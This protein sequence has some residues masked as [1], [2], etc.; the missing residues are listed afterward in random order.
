MPF[1]V[2]GAGAL[3]LARLTVG[4][5]ALRDEYVDPAGD[6]PSRLKM[7]FDAATDLVTF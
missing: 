1:V 3:A 6:I 2:A 7:S 5:H 4:Y